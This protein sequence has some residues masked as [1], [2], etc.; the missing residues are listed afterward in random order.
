MK[1]VAVSWVSRHTRCA[2]CGQSAT[3]LQLDGLK[4][5]RCDKHLEWP[6]APIHW[7][8]DDA[9]MHQDGHES[10]G[11]AFLRLFGVPWES[12]KKAARYEDHGDSMTWTFPNGVVAC[13]ACDGGYIRWEPFNV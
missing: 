13:V 6:D 3:E 7:H 12:A 9:T 11:A 5:P 8:E 1:R 2:W 4:H 10:V